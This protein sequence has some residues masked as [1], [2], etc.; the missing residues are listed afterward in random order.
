M[1]RRAALLSGAA[2]VAWCVLLAACRSREPAE[3]TMAQPPGGGGGPASAA[4]EDVG[5][6]EEPERRPYGGWEP[7]IEAAQDLARLGPAGAGALRTAIADEQ[8]A[9]RAVAALALLD[10][11]HADEGDQSRVEGLLVD[12]DWSVRTAAGLALLEAS[13]RF[14]AAFCIAQLAEAPEAT[15]DDAARAACLLLAAGKPRAASRLLRGLPNLAVPVVCLLRE[16]L[17]DPDA[18]RD[19][20]E[21]LGCC[22]ASGAE[23]A[24]DLDPARY[25]EPPDRREAAIALLRLGC[26]LDDA[27]RVLAAEPPD[28]GWVPWADDGRPVV[29]QLRRSISGGGPIPPASAL[30]IVRAMGPQASECVPE[31]LG[32]RESPELAPLAFCAVASIGAPAESAIPWL[33]AESASHRACELW[34]EDIPRAGPPPLE[35]FEHVGPVRGGKGPFDLD[36]APCPLD[37]VALH[38][39]ARIAPCRPDVVS[40]ALKRLDDREPAVREAATLSLGDAVALG[41]VG[42]DA[43]PARDPDPRVRAA[44]A[45][46]LGCAARRGRAEA[47]WALAREIEEGDAEHAA[48]A[49]AWAGE[50]EELARAMES[51]RPATRT[52][53]AAVLFDPQPPYP[54]GEER[55]PAARTE[56]LRRSRAAAVIESSATDEDPL[57][58]MLSIH[59]IGK[60]PQYFRATWARTLATAESDPD[61]AVAILA[62]VCARYWEKRS[63]PWEESEPRGPRPGRVEELSREMRD[64]GRSTPL[65][66]ALGGADAATLAAVARDESLLP[67]ERWFAAR[68]LAAHR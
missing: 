6:D 65:D 15:P 60:E 55:S 24:A 53:A 59:V 64:G 36:P 58:R 18:R 31:I 2:L 37:A 63:L 52:W 62:H 40:A 54:A 47:S 39:A 46:V 45:T 7:R 17:A 13:D 33:L 23:A 43:M 4:V 14:D 34:R 56:E 25:E 16:V 1:V 26:R 5:A 41:Q 19:A 68:A 10:A 50:S 11:E 42:P 12:R 61:D 8:P 32:L 57:V 9:V 20:M 38:A 28:V 51:A 22:G 27:L 29:P 21:L 49:L 3:R 67:F 66:L 30:R 35:Q 48:R 44:A